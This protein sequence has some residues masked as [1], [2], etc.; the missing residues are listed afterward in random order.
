MLAVGC[1]EVPKA[2]GGVYWAG[3]KPDKREFQ[4]GADS[5]EEQKRNMISETLALL[6]RAGWFSDSKA[7][8]DDAELLKLAIGPQNPALTKESKIR[9]V[10]EYGRAVHAEMAALTNAS[11]KGTPVAGCAMYVTTFPCHLCARHIVSA[12]IKQVIYTEPYPKSLTAEL[13]LDSISVEGESQDRKHIPFDVFVGVA[14]RQYQN[15]F[16]SGIRKDKEG[17]AIKFTKDIAKLRYHE[18]SE[19]YKANEVREFKALNTAMRTKGI[20]K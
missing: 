19:I 8:L 6:K 1:N 18:L 9:N 5:S 17:K 13:Y 15:L 16:T 3:D 7:K 14:P 4:E 10:I 2:G 12:G 20:I 11:R